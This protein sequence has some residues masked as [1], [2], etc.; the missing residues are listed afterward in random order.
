MKIVLPKQKIPLNFEKKFI[1][2]HT[3]L[4]KKGFEARDME[5]KWTIKSE[6]DWVYFIRS[7]TSF[8]IYGI[9]LLETPYG[10][11]VVDSWVSRDQS[12][13]QSEDLEE[14]R[15]L[16]EMILESFLNRE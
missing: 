16:L 4:L 3:Q 10:S 14:N 15:N 6:N 2:P 5:D 8:T 13:Y 1:R 12:Q 9:R 11:K 7:W